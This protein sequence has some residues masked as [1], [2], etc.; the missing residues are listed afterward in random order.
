MSRTLI[1]RENI[2]SSD[3]M[4]PALFLVDKDTLWNRQPKGARPPHD[5]PKSCHAPP[6]RPA[7]HFGNDEFIFMATAITE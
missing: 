3:D 4:S 1:G 7:P 5:P 2:S 6:V